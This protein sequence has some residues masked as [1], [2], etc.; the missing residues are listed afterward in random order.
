M[1][2]KINLKKI[3]AEPLLK[4]NSAVFFYDFRRSELF[5]NCL[6]AINDVKARGTC[7]I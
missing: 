5:H 4:R 1:K 7:G 6:F 2:L 3:I